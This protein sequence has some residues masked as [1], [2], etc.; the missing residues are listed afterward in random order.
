MCNITDNWTGNLPFKKISGD[1]GMCKT[2]L[3]NYGIHK[4][5]IL[6]PPEMEYEDTVPFQEPHQPGYTTGRPNVRMLCEHT[7]SAKGLCD[8]FL[9]SPFVILC[10]VCVLLAISPPTAF[11]IITFHS[12][13]GSS[14]LAIT[15]L[16]LWGAPIVWHRHS[17][18][19]FVFFIINNFNIYM[20]I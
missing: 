19:V 7:S 15:L 8:L 3:H 5:D 16:Y 11:T 9:F 12:S 13:P 17:W 18:F 14:S 2:V 4:G 6:P 10:C 1:H 20:Y